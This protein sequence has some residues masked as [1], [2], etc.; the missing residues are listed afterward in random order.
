MATALY[1]RI[2]KD[3]HGTEL[4]VD[5]QLADLHTLA[6]R[7]E[8]R[9]IALYVDNNISAARKRGRRQDRPEFLRLADDVK[10]GLVDEILAWDFDR[11]FRDPLEAEE[12]FLMCEHRGL[13]KIASLGDD[14]DIDS[15]EGLM[16]ARIKAAVAAEE[17]RK[18]RKRA[19]RKHL[20]LAEHG[21]RSGG[22][23]R[24]FGW[25]C[26][27][28]GQC[29]LAGC[30]HDGRSLI[31]AEADL[32]RAAAARILAGDSIRSVCADWTARGVA[33]VTGKAWT[34]TT[35]KRIVTAGRTCGWRE[36][37]GVL[38][39]P[40]AGV[41]AVLDRDVVEQLRAVLR[42]PARRRNTIARRYLLSGGLARCGQCGGVV[43]TPL[44]ARPRDDGRRRY[45]CASGPGF[46]GCGRTY[47]LADPLEDLVADALFEAVD[48]PRY[49]AAVAGRTKIAATGDPAAEAAVCEAKLAELAERWAADDLTRGEWA[50]A[51]Q[52]V[53]SRLDAARRRLAARRAATPVVVAP[54]SGHALR[55]A[56]TSGMSLDA[57]R[58]AI[59]DVFDHVTVGP[60][61]RGY[62]R[63]DADRVTF[64]WRT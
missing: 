45:V 42:D 16:V 53:Q 62:N 59:F 12:F 22:G 58:A 63:F 43:G 19:A 51:R 2:S 30:S 25:S 49:A 21:H 28:P 44:V 35:L 4:G 39:A 33:T 9:D 10:N 14:V 13:V 8:S 7:R 46:A 18:I 40:L 1:A 52:A 17:V 61:R 55:D 64:D 38:T 50:A 26:T 47:V 27:R 60:G 34:Q 56:W 24:P 48:S 37:H 6:D 32:I 31:P 57:K 23:T 5:R 54:G 29:R 15:G 41:E 3:R 36:H 11:L 20:E